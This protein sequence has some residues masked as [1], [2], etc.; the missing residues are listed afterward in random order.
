MLYPEISQQLLRQLRVIGK[1][2]SLDKT[3]R[4]GGRDHR[5]WHRGAAVERL[6]QS[7][8]VDGVM[9]GKTYILVGKAEVAASLNDNDALNGIEFGFEVGV[10][11]E[12]LGFPHWHFK[13]RSTWPDWTAAT[14][15]KDP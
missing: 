7:L 4:A 5:Q 12:T 1:G 8:L 13:V 9:R 14:R 6:R 10:L 3:G 11:H 2:I 15:R